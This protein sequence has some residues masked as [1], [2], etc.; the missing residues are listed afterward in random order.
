M[1]RTK[2]EFQDSEEMREIGEGLLNKYCG[3][4]FGLINPDTI[5]FAL[6]VSEKA[7][8]AKTIVVERNPKDWIQEETKLIGLVAAYEEDW[9]T[10]SQARK[11]FEVLEALQGLPIDTEGKKQNPDVQEYKWRVDFVGA[12]W[13]EKNDKGRDLPSLLDIEDPNELKELDPSAPVT[14]SDSLEFPSDDDE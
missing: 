11:E 13:R 10:W 14:V 4:F 6:I 5:K 3:H 1:A 9:V 7:K 8:N 12:D 2:R